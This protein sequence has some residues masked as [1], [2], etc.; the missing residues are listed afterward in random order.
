MNLE[1]TYIKTQQ[2]SNSELK[3]LAKKY[4]EA[5]GFPLEVGMLGTGAE[6]KYLA[7]VS[8]DGGYS[9]EI[10]RIVDLC[11]L[12]RNLDDLTEITEEDLDAIL[13]KKPKSGDRDSEQTVLAPAA[14]APFVPKYTLFAGTLGEF[15]E[16]Y[17][18][19]E[20][21]YQLDAKGDGYMLSE[22][23]RSS[24]LKSYYD[25]G[26]FTKE[27]PK[28]YENLGDGVLC[29]VLDNSDKVKSIAIVTDTHDEEYVYL[30]S[31]GSIWQHALPFTK[32]EALIY[33]WGE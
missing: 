1:K 4:S 18:N 26:V 24:L 30:D 6:W 32:E 22:D 31:E 21:F 3:E 5:S 29:W 20:Q 8:D 25:G 9:N 14:P 33:V 27:E 28:W 10:T 12:D 17:I 7:S 11:Y 19:G 15:A 2:L 13:A 16:R 23:F